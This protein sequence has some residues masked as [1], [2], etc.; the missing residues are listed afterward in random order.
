MKSSN[1]TT[2]K[3]IINTT[4][5]SKQIDDAI[6]E[7][8]LTDFISTK[9]PPATYISVGRK[10]VKDS[11]TALLNDMKLREILVKMPKRPGAHP[12]K[13][14]PSKTVLVE[15]LYGLD[16][17]HREQIEKAD[18]AWLR[19][20]IKYAVKHNCPVKCATIIRLKNEAEKA[21]KSAIARKKKEAQTAEFAAKVENSKKASSDEKFGAALVDLVFA[22]EDFDFS[23]VSLPMAENS[24]MLM[25][26]RP[27]DMKKALAIIDLWQFS[28][29]DN[30]IWNRDFSK[31]ESCWSDNKHT[32]ILIASK[33]NPEKPME[34]FKLNSV[35]YERQTLET[36]YIPDYY[37]DMIEQMCPGLQYL[38]VF[39]HRQYSDSWHFFDTNF[40]N[41]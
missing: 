5:T 17:Y 27:K 19:K 29:I 41:N 3:S 39:S 40:D 22:P 20:T 2:I 21:R 37:Y 9:L 36:V 26:V 32:V 8:G 24:L 16:R 12:G 4:L 38:E 13:E 15:T 14:L 28:Y 30:V 31:P 6:K 23:S 7:Y 25:A 18:S 1:T 33:G 34:G 10:S 35:H 11:I